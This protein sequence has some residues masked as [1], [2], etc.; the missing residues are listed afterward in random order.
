M[1]E[2]V[3]ISKFLHK[4]VGNK[5]TSIREKYSAK[6]LKMLKPGDYFPLLPTPYVSQLA[7][8]DPLRIDGF[9]GEIT[10]KAASK[11]FG[12][13]DLDEF[14]FWS[15]RACGIAGVQMVIQAVQG[16][17]YK[18]MD[19]IKE[20]LKIGGYKEKDD[21]GWYHSKLAQLAINHGIPAKVK[22][23]IPSSEIANQVNRQNYVLASVKSETGGHLVLIYG[24]RLDKNSKLAGFWLH[25]P[26]N[27]RRIGS[28]V[29]VK[30]ED[31]DRISTHRAITF[32]PLP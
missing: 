21:T 12:A 30:K 27:Y 16:E 28:N 15:W 24:F 20:C 6:E 25:D 3:N 14:S 7:G 2:R 9:Y 22:K 4:T 18:T 29:F 31:F 23:F 5:V 11:R 8:A 32:A 17:K 1:T 26:S 13:K 19:L 10:D